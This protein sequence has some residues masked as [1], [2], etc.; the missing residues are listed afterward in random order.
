MMRNGCEERLELRRQHDV[1]ERHGEHQR[2]AHRRRRFLH[3]LDVAGKAPLEV[4]RHRDRPRS[5]SAPPRSRRRARPGARSMPIFACRRRC[6]AVDVARADP[7]RERHDVAGAHDRAARRVERRAE[8]SR[9]KS[10][11]NSGAS[12]TRM[13]C[14]WSPSRSR[15]GTMPS[16]MPRSCVATAPTLNPRSAAIE[17]LTRPPSRAGRSRGSCRRPPRRELASPWPGLRSRRAAAPR[18]RRRARRR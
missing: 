18:C 14:S 6:F 5:P 3:Q 15:V 1:D 7:G 9:R 17:R 13:S 11:R 2:Q 12:R 16:T 10:F 4:R 8:R